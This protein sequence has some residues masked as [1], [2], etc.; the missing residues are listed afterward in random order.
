MLTLSWSHDLMFDLSAWGLKNFRASSL[1]DLYELF[2]AIRE[3][4]RYERSK[5]RKGAFRPQIHKEFKA[6]YKGK[7]IYLQEDRERFLGS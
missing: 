6:V 5:R 7:S 4:S 3:I 2:L 1:I